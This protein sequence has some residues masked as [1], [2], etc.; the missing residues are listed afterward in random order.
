MTLLEEEIE[1]WK[2]F[3][4]ALRKEDRELWDEMISQVRQYYAEAVEKSEKPL[5]TDPFLMSLLLV[6]QRMIEEL[7]A[8]LR[9]S[10]SPHL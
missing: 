7:K 9:A 4:W 2:G 3:P 10:Q 5:T 8:Q 1:S 6:Q